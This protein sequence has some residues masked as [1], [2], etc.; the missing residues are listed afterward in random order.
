MIKFPFFFCYKWSRWPEASHALARCQLNSQR[1]AKI[2]LDTIRSGEATQDVYVVR[3]FR[4][5][6]DRIAGNIHEVNIC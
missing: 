2:R 5:L 3:Y 6:F 4:L 1:A